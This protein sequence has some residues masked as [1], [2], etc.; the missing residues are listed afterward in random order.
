MCIDPQLKIDIS[1]NFECLCSFLN[2][3]QD[4]ASTKAKTVATGAAGAVVSSKVGLPEKVEDGGCCTYV[5][6]LSECVK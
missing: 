2:V 1:I 6:L 4:M 5:L 3:Q